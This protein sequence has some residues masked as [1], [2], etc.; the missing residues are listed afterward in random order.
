L[1]NN[2]LFSAILLPLLFIA[3]STRPNHVLSEKKME[4]VL[5]DL[6]IAEAEISDNYTIFGNNQARKKDLMHAL[7][8][9]H[10]ISEAVFD[11]SLV[12]YA[13][14]LDKY[15]KINERV[16]ARYTSLME[17][18]RQKQAKELAEKE[19]AEKRHSF[20]MKETEFFLSA[21]DLPQ[22]VYTFRADTS[23]A[24]YGGDYELRLDIL[25]VSENQHLTV[26]FYARCA[27]TVF[28]KRDTIC[29]NGTFA[30]TV[31]VPQGK[32]AKELSGAIH[33]SDISSNALFYI[34]KLSISNSLD[35][36]HPK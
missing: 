19:L 21:A 15:V 13:D 9:K 32:M 29:G 27:D 7:F 2:F 23:L 14:N 1:R 18:M 34:S 5:Y 31:N 3:C 28:V 17:E 20:P 24:S 8:Q 35:D 10:K 30:T 16:V 36:L 22:S 6:Y 26:N 33:F 12:W 4:A 11:T 25:G